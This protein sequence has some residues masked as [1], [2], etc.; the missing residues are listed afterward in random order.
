MSKQEW[1]NLY[2]ILNDIHSDFL[3]SYRTYKNGKNKKIRDEADRKVDFAISLA[4]KKIKNNWEAFE[5]LTGG[6][7]NSDYSRSIIYNE[8]LLANY[9][10]NDMS[11]FL[12][13]IQEKITSLT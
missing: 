9:F 13:K 8:F 10:G 3:S 6:K 12:K 5:L 7:E 4:D 11:E 1:E 2:I